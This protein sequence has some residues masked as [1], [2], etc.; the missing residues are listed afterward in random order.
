MAK[1]LLYNACCMSKKFPNLDPLRFLLASMVVIYH[2]PSISRTVGLPA[3]DA[4]P[5]FQKGSEAVFVFF[6]LSGFLIIRSLFA[7]KEKTGT[8][9]IKNFYLRRILRIYPVY[10]FVL[11]FGF[12]FY[13]L[14]LPATGIPYET[15]YDVLTGIFL[16]VA[17]LPNVFQVLFEPGGIL[18][19][20][21]SIGIEEQFYLLIAPVSYFLAK[22][23]FVPFLLGFSIIFFL[24]YFFEPY[25]FFAKYYVLF[26]YFSFGGLLSVLNHQGKDKWLL[27]SQPLQ[28]VLT[29]LVGVY[30]L[31]NAFKIMPQPMYH[32]V[33]MV[34]FG[35]FVLNISRNPNPIFII[36]NRAWIYLGKVSYGVYM[37]HM[38]VVNVILFIFTKLQE[39]IAL[40]EVAVIISINV[41]TIGLTI[42]M[43][44]LS[45]KYYE[46]FF[47]SLKANFRKEDKKQVNGTVEK[48]IDNSSQTTLNE[49]VEMTTAAEL[50]TQKKAKQ[51]N[52]EDVKMSKPPNELVASFYEKRTETS[53][54]NKMKSFLEDIL[55]MQK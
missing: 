52:I 15:N 22:K 17:F 25:Q 26:F 29:G 30:F 43:S 28:Y 41:L 45:F 18:N 7:E 53:K 38:I 10:Y 54:R 11:I 1:S 33:S 4:L 34:I 14:I 3:F 27:L 46:N 20:L 37:Y 16:C 23:R 32:F 5:I 44:H 2:I 21:W 47:L 24:V 51:L 48:T 35:F 49:K 55:T 36:K 31:T 42:L 8:I 13:H 9:S 6:T 39:K 40:P 50:S 12:L 19:I